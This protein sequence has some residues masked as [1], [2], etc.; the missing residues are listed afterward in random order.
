ME[1]GSPVLPVEVS[2]KIVR[3]EMKERDGSHA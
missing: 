3:K 2:K 1:I